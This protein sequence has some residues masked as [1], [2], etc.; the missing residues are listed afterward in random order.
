M[1]WIK[2]NGRIEEVKDYIRLRKINKTDTVAELKDGIRAII[3][4]PTAE[5]IAKTKEN[6]CT[7]E[8]IKSVQD[9]LRKPKILEWLND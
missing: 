5:D 6:T 3:V 7:D 4:Y 1:A 2:R 9:W 8:E